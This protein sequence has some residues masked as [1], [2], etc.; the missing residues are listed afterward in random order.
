MV[1]TR[2][3]AKQAVGILGW[4]HRNEYSPDSGY[5]NH[6]IESQQEYFRTASPSRLRGTP[7]LA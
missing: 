5:Q 1:A 7:L 4:Y 6:V 3:I 2:A